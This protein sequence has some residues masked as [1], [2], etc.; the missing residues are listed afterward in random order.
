MKKALALTL[1]LLT[2]FA[3]TACGS[4]AEKEEGFPQFNFTHYSSGGVTEEFTAVILFE[5]SN[6]TFTAYQVGFT[7]CTCRDTAVNFASVMYVELLNTKQTAAEAAIRT[8]SFGKK[9]GYTAGFWG[10]S[11]P[12]HGKPEYTKDYMDEN[13]VQKLVKKTKAEFDAWEG[14]G[15][16]LS[17]I[18]MDA[19]TG[20]TVSTS[21][22]TSVLKS[23]FEYHA[24]KYYN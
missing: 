5:R 3:L 15:K 8:I 2:V 13:F 1:A 17:G 20:A 10:D 11:D 9:D 23:L 14:Y 6:S 4:T 21:N 16:G 7:S 22:I 12:I 24:N 19:L 18:D